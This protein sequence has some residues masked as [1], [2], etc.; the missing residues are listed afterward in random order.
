MEVYGVK[1]PW[2]PNSHSV[3]KKDIIESY[4]N[5]QPLLH[6]TSKP[7]WSSDSYIFYSFLIFVYVFCHK[8]RHKIEEIVG[9]GKWS[10]ESGF[11]R[12]RERG[13]GEHTEYEL[14][15]DEIDSI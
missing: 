12:E 11:L 14:M 4:Q 3:T 6:S 2:P 10:S 7:S 13:G 5:T 8:T 1:S 9:G 15:A